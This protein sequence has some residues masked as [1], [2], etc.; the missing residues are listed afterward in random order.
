MGGDSKRSPHILLAEDDAELRRVLS[1]ALCQKGYVVTCTSNGH[2]TLVVLSAIARKERPVPDAIVMDV[3]MPGRSG[4]ELL[5]ALRLAEWQ[6]SVILMTA[7][8]SESLHS[9]AKELGAKVLLDK[10]FD[11]EALLDALPRAA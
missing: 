7:F 11:L 6:T 3:R 8:G 1:Y 9:H 2:E 10:P 4:L 5:L